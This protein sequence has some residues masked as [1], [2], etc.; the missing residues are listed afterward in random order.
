MYAYKL[1]PAQ[2]Y[3]SSINCGKW[4]IFEMFS[5]I[6]I[7]ERVN[8]HCIFFIIKCDVTGKKANLRTDR[9]PKFIFR[10]IYHF[11]KN[12]CE[13]KKSMAWI[14]VLF[15]LLIKYVEWFFHVID[16]YR[17]RRKK[18]SA[19]SYEKKSRILC[20]EM[21]V[22]TLYACMRIRIN[23][24]Y[25]NWWYSFCFILWL[26]FMDNDNTEHTYRI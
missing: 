16:V 18:N 5:N 19:I 2:F 14:F 22:F 20:V 8:L 1:N 6:F 21:K 10:K 23:S 11:C 4:F 12:L 15:L 7:L 17:L 9:E 24:I 3:Y 25:L 26:N 13:K